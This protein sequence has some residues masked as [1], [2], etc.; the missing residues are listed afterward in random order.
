MWRKEFILL[1]FSQSEKHSDKMSCKEL[2]WTRFIVTRIIR[3]RFTLR[4]NQLKC[5]DNSFFCLNILKVC[6]WGTAASL[7]L[8]FDQAWFDLVTVLAQQHSV[9]HEAP[10]ALPLSGGTG[11]SEFHVPH[12]TTPSCCSVS[13]CDVVE[14]V[15]TVEVQ[16]TRLSVGRLWA[17]PSHGGVPEGVCCSRS[18]VVP[19]AGLEK[20]WREGR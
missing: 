11:P 4:Q 13:T 7:K 5:T 18:T 20:T 1:T 15:E 6:T 10:A 8:L 14:V 16:T 12:S 9:W 19:G 17:Q 2:L 3:K